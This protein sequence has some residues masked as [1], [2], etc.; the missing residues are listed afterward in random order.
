MI[1]NNSGTATVQSNIS[2]IKGKFS[3]DENSIEHLMGILTVMYSDE[4]TACIREYLTNALDSHIEAGQTRPIEVT[5]PSR[6]NPVYTIQDFGVGMSVNDIIDTYSKYGKST[7]RGSNEFTGMLGIGSKSALAYTNSF[8]ITGVKDGVLTQAIINIDENGVPEYNIVDTS[9]TDKSN[10]VKI[11]IPVK[12]RNSF[13]SKTRELLKFWEPGLV[14]VDGAEPQRHDYAPVKG[15]EGV[16]I[17]HSSS[18]LTPSSYIVMGNVPYMINTDELPLGT[19]NSFGFIAYVPIG[20]V[21]IAP[22]RE[23][24]NYTSKT[25]KVINDLADGLFEDYVNS[26]VDRF[27][28]MDKPLDAL[29]EYE[30]LPYHVRNIPAIK[31]LKFEGYGLANRHTI[32][33]ENTNMYMYYNDRLR[34]ND[35]VGWLD[36]SKIQNNSLIVVGS[37]DK[38]SPSVRRKCLKY[39]ED[40]DLNDFVIF[41]KQDTPLVWLRDLPRVPLEDIKAI[42]LPRAASSSPRRNNV[43]YTVYTVVNGE[44]KVDTTSSITGKIAYMSPADLRG[45]RSWDSDV[46][47]SH[48]A[49]L[50]PEYSLV[51]LGKN[52]F[53]KFLKAFPTAVPVRKA[54]QSRVDDLLA[55]KTVS[56][57]IS[58]LNY[59]LQRAVRALNTSLIDDPDLVKFVHGMLQ[60]P[61]D[62]AWTEAGRIAQAAKKIKATVSVPVRQVPKPYTDKYP[63]LSHLDRVNDQDVYFYLN[64]KFAEMEKNK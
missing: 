39:V 46:P 47:P 31:T 16:Y 57:A 43:P 6:F 55:G 54:I 23:A 30:S 21:N 18:Y 51:I 49:L 12:D 53:D 3:M 5:T 62:E 4:E 35:H 48:A 15:R 36:T 24:L 32:A 34:V 61:N 7:K 40:N 11:A 38:P 29:R 42:K 63:L 1:P 26:V 2:G 14:L 25:K 10:G 19:R 50:V 8:T 59:N 58:D 13:E 52:R 28:G 44:V 17:R 56:L 20:A 60:N 22:S 41:L 27:A 37:D 64:A 33:I 9:V 45:E